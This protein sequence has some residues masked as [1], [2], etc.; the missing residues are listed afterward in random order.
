MTEPQVPVALE[1]IERFARPTYHYPGLFLPLRELYSATS[2]TCTYLRSSQETRAQLSLDR[3][4]GVR[5]S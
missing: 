5:C 1:R 4:S 3:P 2:S